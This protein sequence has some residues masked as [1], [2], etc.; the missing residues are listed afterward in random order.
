[1]LDK[2]GNPNVYS[3]IHFNTG[4]AAILNVSNFLKEPVDANLKLNL[5]AIGFEPDKVKMTDTITGEAVE[6]KGQNL[7]L[8]ILDERWRMIYIEPSN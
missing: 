6:L 8:T 5:K 3:S 1:M 4:K 2:T 7:A